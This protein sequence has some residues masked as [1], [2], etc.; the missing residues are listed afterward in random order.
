MP[1]RHRRCGVELVL[2][3]V[4]KVSKS[5]RESGGRI[6]FSYRLGDDPASF[7]TMP[8]MSGAG[9][10]ADYGGRRIFATTH[11]SVVLAAGDTDSPP[12]RTA[13]ETLCRAWY[14]IYVY[15]RRRGYGAG[16]PRT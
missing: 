3:G 16:T 14:P 12:A 4:Q 11:W 10:E 13:L 15:V 5:R 8:Q 6:V 7:V 1:I 2:L 9:R